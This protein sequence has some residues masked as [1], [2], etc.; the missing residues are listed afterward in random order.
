MLTLQVVVSFCCSVDTLQHCVAVSTHCTEL[1]CRH[2]VLCCSLECSLLYVPLHCSTRHHAATHTITHAA[3]H[4]I[5]H[6]AE[7]TITHAH[8]DMH[9]VQDCKKL[10]H[11][12]THSITHA[13][14][15]TRLAVYCNTLQHTAT[16]CSTL[17]HTTTHC[18]TLQHTATHIQTWIRTF[19][20]FK[21]SICV[22]S[23]FVFCPTVSKPSPEVCCCDVL[24][25]VAVC[26]SVF[27]WVTVCCS[28]LQCVAAFQTP[29]FST[30]QF[31][32]Y[33]LVYDKCGATCC[34]VLH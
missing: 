28:A 14:V 18:N 27:R 10:Q 31:Q 6:A 7:H 2:T 22:I 23:T 3:T 20:D 8:V 9:R 5:T 13:H 21:V 33:H 29:L 19:F 15:H 32:K 4:T 34:G 30:P 24:Q 16:H 17:Q 12:A 26:R 25:C 1:Q 11:R